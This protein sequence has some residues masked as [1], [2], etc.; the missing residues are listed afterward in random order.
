MECVCVRAIVYILDCFYLRYEFLTRDK[1][2]AH[3]VLC[4]AAIEIDAT[5]VAR[6]SSRCVFFSRT[7]KFFYSLF[8]LLLS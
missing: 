7:Y 5:L 2:Y 3:T 1:K 6:R 4:A 8:C